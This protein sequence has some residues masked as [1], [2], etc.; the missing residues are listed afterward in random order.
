LNPYLGFRAGYARML[1]DGA[2][3]IGGALGLELW[4]T[5]SVIIDLQ[6]RA[7]ALIQ[8]ADSTHAA[9]QPALGANFAY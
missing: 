8:V 4:K 1:G 3:A 5:E 2:L 7:Y 6:L 9:L